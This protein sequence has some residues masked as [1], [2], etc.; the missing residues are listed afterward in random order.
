LIID[1]ELIDT[2]KFGLCLIC[3]KLFYIKQKNAEPGLRK[4]IGLHWRRTLV[5]YNLTVPLPNNLAITTARFFS[6]EPKIRCKENIFE[7]L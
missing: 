1:N 4:P 3:K 6:K 2:Y 5:L 7:W